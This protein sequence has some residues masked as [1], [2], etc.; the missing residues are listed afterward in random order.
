MNIT[1]QIGPGSTSTTRIY[2]SYAYGDNR[3]QFLCQKG[4]P[5][6]C[7]IP[8]SPRTMSQQPVVLFERYI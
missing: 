5:R 7:N 1:G 8:P 3:K 2:P 6:C 4:S